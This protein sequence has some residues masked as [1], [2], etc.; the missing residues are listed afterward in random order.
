MEPN[1][2]HRKPTAILSADV[3]GYG[4]PMGEDEE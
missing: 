4:Q 1:G 3:K 2:Y